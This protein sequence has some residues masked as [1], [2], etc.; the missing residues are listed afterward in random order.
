MATTDTGFIPRSNLVGR[1]TGIR[2][3]KIIDDS[4][5]LT[6]GDMVREYTTG[7]IVLAAAG[8]P[9]YGCVV[10][11]EDAN[12]LDLDNA[13][14]TFTGGTWT[15][16]TKTVITDS[17]N[18]TVDQIRAI[19]DID[20]MTVYSNQ[21][22]DTINTT[23]SSGKC[24]FAGSYVDLVAASDQVDET[25]NGVAFNVKAQLYCHGLDPENTARGLYSIAEHQIWGG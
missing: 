6:I 22:D 18:T 23:S 13:R 3:S 8:N 20:P 10:G 21:P 9:I 17:D 14:A 24:G 19:I 1:S 16:S 15:S 4:T 2:R 11:F 25:N 7:F 12:G 5:T